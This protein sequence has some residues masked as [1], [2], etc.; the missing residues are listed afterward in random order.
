[1]TGV[2]LLRGLHLAAV[3]SV[4]GTTAF[5]AWTMPAAADPRPALP[6]LV[7]LWRLGGWLAL[8]LGAGWFVAQS[9]EIADAQT[10]RALM[11]AL[12]V[13]AARTRFGEVLDVRT[14]LL[15]VAVLLAGP[16][17]RR[18]LAALVVTGVAAG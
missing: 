9:V 11:D 3:L 4:M 15:L 16:S 14:V 13:V 1:M 2:A 5:I 10:L 12:P 18:A 7:R 17:R 8:V 6:G